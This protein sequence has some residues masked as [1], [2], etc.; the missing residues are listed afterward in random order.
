MD[1]SISLL[2]ALLLHLTLLVLAIN[3]KKYFELVKKIVYLHLPSIILCLVTSSAY[4]YNEELNLLLSKTKD[5]PKDLN[6]P[7][8]LLFFTFIY[9]ISSVKN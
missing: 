8:Y 4:L 9:T 1:L 7:R 6:I 3:I 5:I 2:S